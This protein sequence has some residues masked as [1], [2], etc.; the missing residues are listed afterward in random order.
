MRF[1]TFAAFMLPL[2][3]L[4]TPTPNP[5]ILNRLGQQMQDYSEARAEAEGGIN[6]VFTE[7]SAISQQAV[8]Q[9]QVSQASTKMQLAIFA[10]VRVTGAIGSGRLPN[11]AE[12][13]DNP[14]RARNDGVKM[15]NTALFAPAETSSSLRAP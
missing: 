1:S 10:D 8:V 4:A 2:A 7:A 9:D 15:I 3:A 5:S 6:R 12:Y 13:V 14:S 11:D